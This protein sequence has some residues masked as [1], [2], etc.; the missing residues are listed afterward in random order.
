MQA[1]RLHHKEQISQLIVTRR[2]SGALCGSP[3]GTT[4]VLNK[5]GTGTLTLANMNTAYASVP[6]VISAGVLQLGDGTTNGS[7]AGNI[8]DNAS[9]VFNNG[10]D[11]TFSNVIT[12]S[13]TVTK[14]GPGTLN[15]ATT[16]FGQIV[17]VTN[18]YAGGT[19]ISGG[20]LNVAGDTSLGAVPATAATNI[21]FNGNGTLQWGA[22]FALNANRQ[23]SIPSGATAGFDIA[24]QYYADD[25]YI[26]GSATIAAAISGAGN[27]LKTDGGTLLLTG[28]NTYAGTTTVNAGT[29]QAATTSSLPGYN[30]PGN[31]L[32]NSGGTLAVNVGTAK[33]TST[34]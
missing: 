3:I 30:T 12:G 13:G 26:A 15:F 23:I 8:A 4:G 7:I 9:L 33:W 6:A 27:L 22:P 31:I 29:L 1:G 18:S 2:L 34:T 24:A 32:I 20:T 16:S 14:T 11:Q 28:T 17:P 5:V 25:T 19:V 10:S 21:T